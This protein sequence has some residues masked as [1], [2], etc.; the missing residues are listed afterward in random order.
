M[1]YYSGNAVCSDGIMH[2]CSRS[3]LKVLGISFV[4]TSKL[5]LFT[6]NSMALGVVPKTKLMQHLTSLSV[7]STISCLF[8]ALHVVPSY[9]MIL[10]HHAFEN[11]SFE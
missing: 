3:L 4:S 10:M 9:S 1:L 7:A 2:Q 5:F 8:D 11:N 6:M